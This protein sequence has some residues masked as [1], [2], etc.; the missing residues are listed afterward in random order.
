MESIN[1]LMVFSCT[2]RFKIYQM[3]IKSAFLNGYL[4]EEVLV[5]QPKGFEDLLHLD[6][7]YKLEKALYCLKQGLRAWYEILTEYLLKI[8]YT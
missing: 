2:L 4:N 1:V 3:D 7:V 8:G 6:H 5:A